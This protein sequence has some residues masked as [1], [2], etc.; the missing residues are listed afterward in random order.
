MRRFARLMN[1]EV[2]EISAP[3]MVR[4][5]QYDWPGNIRELQNVLERAVIVAQGPVL[6][7]LLPESC[8]PA[9]A[10]PPA[11]NEAL[12]EVE[13]RHILAVLEKT[14]G[15]VGG[16]NGAALRLGMKRSTLNF[17]MKKLGAAAPCPV[18]VAATPRPAPPAKTY[19]VVEPP[20]DACATLRKRGDGS[21]WCCAVHDTPARRAHRYSYQSTLPFESHDASVNPVQEG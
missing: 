14:A 21:A 12:R 3:S 1:K 6:E 15:V 20:C 13:R 10:A 4:R 5:V 17:R 2:R 7:V 19:P 16:P 9:A 8:R 18:L 11:P